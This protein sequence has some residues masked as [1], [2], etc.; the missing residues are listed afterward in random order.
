MKIEPKAPEP[1]AQEPNAQDYFAGLY[2][3]SNDPW[4]LRE[5]WYER[6]KRALT[7]AALPDEHYRRAYEPGCANGELTAELAARCETLLAADLNPAAVELARQRVAHLQHVRVEQRAMPDDW[8]DGEFNLIVISE[9]AYYLN[10]AQLARLIAKLTV[11]LAEGGT[12]IACH[13]RRP[14]EGWPHSGD[15]VHRQLRAKLTLS[16]LSCYQDD[17]MVLDVWSSNAESIY[18]REAR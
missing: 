15:H 2:Q 6:R 18:Q 1:R 13:W 4:L 14:I 9:V 8:P 17:D 11:S 10:E 16:R 12:L 3:G 7:L 5:R